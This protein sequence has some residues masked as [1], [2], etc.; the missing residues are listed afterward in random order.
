MVVDVIFAEKKGELFRRLTNTAIASLRA[1]ET[2]VRFDVFVIEDDGVKPFNYNRMMCNGIAMGM[3]DMVIMSNNDVVFHKG[4]MTEVLAVKDMTGAESFGLWDDRWHAKK[5]HFPSRY[6]KGYQV[7]KHITGWCIVAD[8]AMIERI[9]FC[10]EPT[11][12]V[13]GWYSDNVYADLLIKH[14]VV[15]VLCAN[16]KVDHMVSATLNE[17]SPQ[18]RWM[19]TYGQR[20]FYLDGKQ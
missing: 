7:G 19:L 6:Y 20:T 18:E 2:N 4:F 17:L 12:R 1:A 9:G 8:R 10:S 15:H 13:R 11:F 3:S 5:F 16:A 14:H